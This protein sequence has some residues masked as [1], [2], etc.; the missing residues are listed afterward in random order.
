MSRYSDVVQLPHSGEPLPLPVVDWAR[1]GIPGPVPLAVT[2]S[3]PNTPL[4]RADVAVLT[5]TSAEWSALDHVFLNSVSTRRKTDRDWERSWYLYG[6]DASRESTDNAGAP[7]W[8]Y[9]RM[10]E[11][12][13]LKAA[14]LRVLLFKCDA[15]LAHPPW[16]Q[17]LT[18]MVG[19]ILKDAQPAWIYSIG[20]AG[21]TREDIRLG[22]VVITNAAHIQLKNPS[23]VAASIN[24]QSFT[25]AGGLPSSEL[26]AQAQEE[27]FFRMSNVVSYPALTNAVSQLHVQAPDSAKFGLDDLLNSALRPEELHVSAARP[28]PGTPLLTTDFYYIASGTDATQWAVLEMDDAVIAAV[29]AQQGVKYAFCRN[30]SDPLV[31]SVTAKGDLIPDAVRDRWSGLVYEDFG[32]YTSFNGAVATWAAIAAQG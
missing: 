10:I 2:Y 3:G 28:M 6:L 18:Q 24:N 15:H 32:F 19:Q 8:G 4:P 22:D 21:G 29:A 30:I 11:L 13:T 17:G 9:Y 26:L 16:I 7:L 25:C 5:W 31:P 23:N 14:K 12:R 27:L 20:T 1:T